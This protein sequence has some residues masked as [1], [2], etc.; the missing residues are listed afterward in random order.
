[1]S[2][3][4][5]YREFKN[6]TLFNRNLKFIVKSQE[7]QPK[8]LYPSMRRKKERITKKKRKKKTKKTNML[9]LSNLFRCVK[10][11]PSP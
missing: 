6:K 7:N 8:R 9:F 11:V 4:K 2:N 1:M 10:L 3:I 5:C